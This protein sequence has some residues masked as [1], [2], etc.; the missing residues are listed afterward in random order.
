ML[1]VFL[2]GILNFT[3]DYFN[4]LPAALITSSSFIIVAISRSCYFEEP[5]TDLVWET[6]SNMMISFVNCW[7]V[8]LIITLVGMTLVE[9]D[10]LRQGND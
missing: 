7:F 8:H 2:T 6:I 3:T 4:F 5:F 10:I 9:A 1:T